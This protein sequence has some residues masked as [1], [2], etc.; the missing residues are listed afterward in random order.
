MGKR[1]GA[2]SELVQEVLGSPLCVACGACA[3]YCPYIVAREDRLAFVA[4]CTKEEGRCYRHCPRSAG[5]TDESLAGDA[6]YRGPLG[7]VAATLI[8]RSL[9]DATRVRRSALP[10]PQHGGTVTAIVAH[11]LRTGTIDAAIVTGW[12]VD[13]TPRTGN[14]PETNRAFEW[15][16][17][18]ESGGNSRFGHMCASAITASVATVPA[19][20][21]LMPRTFLAD[22]PEVVLS[23]AGSKFAVS[24]T[25]AVVN[26]A[27]KRGYR[28]LGVVAL[29]CQ[30]TALRKML[31]SAPPETPAGIALIVGLFCTWS[32]GQRDWADLLARHVGDR[33]VRKVDIPPPPAQI[34]EVELAG[35]GRVEIPLEEVRV[36]VR[37]ACRFCMDM[38]SENADL[39]IGLVEGVAGWNT[40]LVR[41][42]VGQSLMDSAQAAGVVEVGILEAGRLAHLAE[43]SLGKKRRAIG[44]AEAVGHDA[45]YLVHLRGY[46]EKVERDVASR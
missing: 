36:A 23:G 39:S 14:T 7:D 3:S 37:D 45:P 43:A 32:L 10:T 13:T 41:T 26:E 18:P 31:L 33:T 1:L 35:G 8:A 5:L 44:E 16:G 4:S 40:V 15:A 11:A 30:A 38:T 24:P 22:T 21:R 27:L 28:R 19:G 46:G 25:V 34:M 20:T 12:D 2:L 42:E 29:P 17:A 6:G 9:V